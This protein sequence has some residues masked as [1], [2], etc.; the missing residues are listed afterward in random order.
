MQKIQRGKGFD[1]SAAVRM[2]I[3]SGNR[4]SEILRTAHTAIF[5]K[6]NLKN[7]EMLGGIKSATDLHLFMTEPENQS[8][9]LYKKLDQ[10]RAG[11]SSN[12]RELLTWSNS[13]YTDLQE[14]AQQEEKRAETLQRQ[15]EEQ[16]GVATMSHEQIMARAHSLYTQ[17]HGSQAERNRDARWM[18]MK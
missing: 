7:P 2:G 15:I 4:D 1:P 8:T 3:I 6:L 5:N 9:D 13:T 17:I 16:K 18:Q 11:I 12:I 10:E 14:K